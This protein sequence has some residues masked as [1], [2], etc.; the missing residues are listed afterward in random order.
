[1]DV[2]KRLHIQDQVQEIRS[3]TAN[4]RT[5]VKHTEP[6]PIPSITIKFS[7]QKIVTVVKTLDCIPGKLFCLQETK[8]FDNP[9]GTQ[10]VLPTVETHIPQYV[11]RLTIM[12]SY[13]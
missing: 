3:N 2:L 4:P 9:A 11:F 8:E 13:Y 5:P 10:F 6:K 1:M 12:K 7:L